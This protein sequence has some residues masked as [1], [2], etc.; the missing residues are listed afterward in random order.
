MIRNM[1]TRG[2]DVIIYRTRYYWRAWIGKGPN[3]LQ[4]NFKRILYPLIYPLKEIYIY[5]SF[6]LKKRNKPLTK[7]VIFAQGRTGS[8]LLRDLLNSHPQIHCDSEI[9]YFNV[10]FPKLVIKGLCALSKKDLYGFKVKIYQLTERQYIQ[11]PKQFMTDLHKER[12]KIIY[13]KRYNILRQEISIQ[14][15]KTRKKWHYKSKDIVS[16]LDKIHI[17][18]AKL[19]EGMKRREMYLAKEKE[20]LEN[21]PHIKVVYENDLLRAENHQ[22][23]LTKIFNYLNIPSTPV[24]TKFIKNNPN[25]LSDFIQNYQEV[26]QAI[27]KTKYAKF[28]E[29]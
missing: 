22:K 23:T 20:V 15:G 8:E 25:N 4:K 17:N 6:F 13:L 11:N 28:V 2:I 26:V 14:S 21:L 24:S 16:K 5:L 9:L 3:S 10:L 18:C 7:F 27:S 12:W 29:N 1:I 19:I